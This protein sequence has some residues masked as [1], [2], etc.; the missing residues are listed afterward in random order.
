MLE[1][2]VLESA[3]YRIDE[4]YV[5][6]YYTWGEEK[7]NSYINGMFNRFQQIAD[8]NIPWRRIPAEFGVKGYFTKYEKHFIYWKVLSDRSIGIV[9]ILHESM[10]KGRR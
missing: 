1:Y 4:I 5:Y 9:S 8:K 3:T 6:S 2:K 7:A 10:D